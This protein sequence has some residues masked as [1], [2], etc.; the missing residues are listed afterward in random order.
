[1]NGL[2]VHYTKLYSVSLD[3]R[4]YSARKKTRYR[5][6]LSARKQLSG[7]LFCNYS[8][9]KELQISEETNTRRFL[10]VA[11]SWK[12]LK[13]ATGPEKRNRALLRQYAGDLTKTMKTCFGEEVDKHLT[14]LALQLA[15]NRIYRTT[16]CATTAKPSVT[17]FS[18]I[19]CWGQC[20]LLFLFHFEEH[21]RKAEPAMPEVHAEL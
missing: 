11:T 15:E 21:I 10:D 2:D 16:E 4:L 17:P 13:S 1:M 20:T 12:A 7:G 9:H 8:S 3:R 5:R 19:T 14:M 6:F 18:L